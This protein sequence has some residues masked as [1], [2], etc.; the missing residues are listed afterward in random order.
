VTIAGH[1]HIDDFAIL[2]GFTGVH[3][4]CRLG[5]LSLTSVFSYVTKDIPAFVIVA[6]RPAEP[7]GINAEGL[8]RRNYSSEAMRNIREAYR[9]I[10]R[11]GL[12]LDEAIAQLEQRLDSQPEVLPMLRSLHGGDRGLIR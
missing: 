2:G 10:Y 4:F 1:V 9:T 5:Q 3:Q 12:K 8:R 11:L 7:R 6:G